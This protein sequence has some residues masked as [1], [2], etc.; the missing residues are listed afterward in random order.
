MAIYSAQVVGESH[1]QPALEA[2]AG[3]KTPA[4]KAFACQAQLIREPSNPYD[5]N[6]VRVDIDGRT[7]GYLSRTLAEDVADCVEDRGERG[8]A[9]M[10]PAMIV[11]GWRDGA[12]EGAYGV[13]LDLEA[14]YIREDRRSRRSMWMAGIALVALFIATGTLLWLR[15]G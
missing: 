3:P 4:R 9:I 6:A 11:G 1:Y 8:A 2:I 5:A 10:C 12:D 7:V 13:R 15:M 14:L